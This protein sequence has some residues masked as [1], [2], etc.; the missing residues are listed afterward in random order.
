ML[1]SSRTIVQAGQTSPCFDADF[2]PFGGERDI[3]STCSQSYNF[4]GKK[5][6]PETDNDDFGA[7]YYSSRLSRWLSPDWSA[8]P[9]P[10]PYANLTNPQTLNLYAMASDN[11][12]TFADLDGHDAVSPGINESS[13]SLTEGSCGGASY[14]DP[15]CELNGQSYWNNTKENTNANETDTLT[16]QLAS[17]PPPT[18]SQNGASDSGQETNAARR[19]AIAATAQADE[20]DTSMPYTPDHATC[21]LFVQREI[22][23]SGAPKPL[24]KKAD[25]SMGA[26]S[27]AEWAE[28]DIPGWRFLKPGEKPEPGDV[29]ARKENFVDA[30]GHSGIVTA[31]SA[32]GEVTVM[33]AHATKIGVDM[34]FA[35]PHTGGYNNVY[36]RYTGN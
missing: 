34:T 6:D 1:G 8:V 3:T 18:Q 35:Q 15:A 26:P 22:A 12:E 17:T 16:T 14:I 28:S 9:A 20:G 27:A 31:V 33:A 29:A 11:P 10:V 30:T 4:E 32:K 21:N 24:V 36:R 13:N 23:K 5:R 19:A 2:L 7:R 25:G